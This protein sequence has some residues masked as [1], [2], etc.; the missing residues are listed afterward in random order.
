MTTNYSYKGSLNPNWGFPKDL[1]CD[2]G[3]TITAQDL[4]KILHKNLGFER[5]L[6][7][8]PISLCE[9]FCAWPEEKGVP[10]D[11]LILRFNE[12]EQSYNKKRDYGRDLYDILTY[13]C[14]KIYSKLKSLLPLEEENEYIALA[15]ND[16]L[17]IKGG[18]FRQKRHPTPGIS[19]L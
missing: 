4:Q 3:Q 15:F 10:K 8:V 19:L 16:G 6:E 12:R 11:V 18:P 2:A 9:R 7:E 13:L 14:S 5:Y 1:F 17:F